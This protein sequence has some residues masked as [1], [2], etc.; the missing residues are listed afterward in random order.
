MRHK[1]YYRI[2][3]VEEDATDAQIK[4]AYRKLARRYHPDVSILQ[5][6]E[7][8]FKE[9]V[10]AYDTLRDAAKRATFDRL[11][12][13][14]RELRPAPDWERQFS[15]VFCSEVFCG[16]ED[17][18]QC[19]LGDLFAMFKD[20]PSHGAKRRSDHCG[21]GIEVTAHITLEQSVSGAQVELEVP[22]PLTGGDDAAR[23]THT[24]RARIPRGARHGQRIRVISDDAD[25]AHAEPRDV[26][27]VTIAVHPH[28]LF[29]VDGD[30]LTLDLP[31]TPWEAALGATVEVP[32]LHGRVKLR[33]PPGT[34]SNRK[35]RLAGL[36]LPKPVGESG[37]LYAVLRIVTPTEL[38]D[39]EK[40]LFAELARASSFEPREHLA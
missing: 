32:T 10:E 2:L 18:A 4:T 30:D 19:D 26:A 33:L 27:Y 31:V 6:A 13:W 28:P 17:A 40:A 36:G 12:Y 1:D 9:V 16:D 23:E 20:A 39:R 15:E 38:S 24:V 14:A 37:D 3:E 5:D 21:N 7:E 29:R 35:L 11:G 34:Q 25:E 8:R 22:V